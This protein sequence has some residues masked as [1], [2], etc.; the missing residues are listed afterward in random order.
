M[1]KLI[2]VYILLCQQCHNY[3]TNV[4]QTEVRRQVRSRPRAIN[5]HCQ[6]LQ[7]LV[8]HG[9]RYGVHD[10]QVKLSQ[11]SLH[12]VAKTFT[13]NPVKDPVDYFNDRLEKDMKANFVTQSNL[14][15]I[16]KTPN[17]PPGIKVAELEQFI[18]MLFC[19]HGHSLHEHSLH[20][21]SLH[22]HSLHEHSLHEHSLHEHSLHS[23]I[24]CI[25][26]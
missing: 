14:F 16:Q 22:E 23:S 13:G 11:P 1:Y 3:K 15:S 7:Y 12:F 17:K 10:S 24:V 9:H 5:L 19:N 21:H 6:Q 4:V 25:R 2:D 20:E 26:A 8:E 18:G